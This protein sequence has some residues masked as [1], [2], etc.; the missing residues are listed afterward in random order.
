[1]RVARRTFVVSTLAVVASPV[2]LR[3][4]RADAPQVVLKLHHSFSSVSGAHDKFLAPW[5]RQV[6]AQSNGRIRIDLFPS[7]QLGGAPAALFDQARDGVADIVW[8]MPSLTPGRFPKIEAWEL[9]FVP[10]RRALVSSK[11]IDDFGRA[12]LVDEF[13]EVHPIC[14]SCSDRG[15]LHANR[16][17]RTVEDMK[18]LRLHV[19]TR[20]AGDAVR[21]L[22][23]VAVP[24]PSAQLPL[25]ITQHVIDGGID[26]WNMM[27]ALK[28]NDLLKT[29]TEFA[30]VSPSSTTFALVMNKAAYDR[31]P[32]DLKAIIDANSGLPAAGMAGTMWDLQAAAASDV[33]AQR[34]DPITTLQPEAVAHWR[35][36][37]Q[38]VTDS[39]L[40]SMKEQ[41]VDGAKLLASAHASLLKYVDEPEPQ[42]AQTPQADQ[43]SE[44]S[45]PSQTARQ[46]QQKLPSEAKVEGSAPAK[47][48]AASAA[49]A[50]PATPAPA[51]GPEVSASAAPQAPASDKPQSWSSW[52]RSWFSSK[53]TASSVP[54]T[55]SAA[56]APASSVAAPSASV[57]PPPAASPVPAAPVPAAPAP[58]ATASVA[59]PPPV[60]APA[61]P[62]VSPPAAPV[63]PAPVVAAPVA[64]PAPIPAPVTPFVKPAAKAID[65]PL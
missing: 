6:Q 46:P 25:A 49:P 45:Q 43:T 9:P 20:F 52:L 14:F 54:A 33:V 7:M 10:S 4:A 13:R 56:H 59:A 38:P 40:K 42:P 48:D 35:K 63:P 21:A 16:P 64:S 62:V 44:S 37:V 11:A 55:S 50:K 5:S 28:L 27:P 32:K 39:W 58:A 47:S 29:H 15:V 65:I 34:G 51:A 57:A 23:A 8:T 36:A 31:L 18:D 24:M 12:N 19:Q 2:V 17:V 41:K 22:G 53:S 60:A 26:P 1:M 30:D 3:F 61:A